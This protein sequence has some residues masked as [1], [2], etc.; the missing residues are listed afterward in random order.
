MADDINGDKMADYYTHADYAEVLLQ[1]TEEI[2]PTKK[3][4][5]VSSYKL[6]FAALVIAFILL[7]ITYFIK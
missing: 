4:K 6:F 7:V 3:Q 2:I 1:A 5:A